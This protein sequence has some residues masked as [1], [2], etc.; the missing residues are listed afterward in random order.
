MLQASQTANA[1]SIFKNTFVFVLR[2]FQ[3]TNV[4]QRVTDE[5]NNIRIL[6]LL[7]GLLRMGFSTPLERRRR[8]KSNLVRFFMKSVR[9]WTPR[10]VLNRISEMVYQKTHPDE[11]WLTK[12]ANKIMANWLQNTDVGVEFGSGRSTIW[13]SQRVK[14]ITSIESN[15]RW[16]KRVC[17]TIERKNLNNIDYYYYPEEPRE[18]YG[19]LPKYVAALTLFPDS[20][21]DFVLVDGLYRDMCALLSIEKVKPGGIIIIDNVNRYLPS[22]VYHT[23]SPNSRTIND[24]PCGY[25]WTQFAERVSQWRYIWTSSGVTD[26]AFFFKPSHS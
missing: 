1:I 26:T 16:H 11:P 21:L 8:T 13:L 18:H 14:H 20:T 6:N 5:A 23:F 2:Q 10:Y 19:D 7:L 12:D 3:S 4:S 24:G 17:E 15:E 9:H 25:V 22:R